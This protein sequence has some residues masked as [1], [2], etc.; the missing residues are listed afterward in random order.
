MSISSLANAAAARRSDFAPI[1]GIP[2]GLA[3]IAR[4]SGTAPAP[5]LPAAAPPPPPPGGQVAPAA[6]QGANGV[7]TALN[8]LFGYIPT[9]VLT[10]YVAVLAAIQKPDK[11]TQAQWIVFWSFLAFTPIVVWIVYAAKVR[12]ARGGAL[13]TAFRAWPVW[14][15]LAATVAYVAWAFALPQT[16]FTQYLWYSSALAGAAVLVT[17]TVLGLLAPLFQR[18]LGT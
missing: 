16:P 9:E 13:P 7:N 4:A 18:P 15:M 5:E 3:E 14:E 11:V 1:G 2:Q 12:I 17:S 8:V 10:L 6:N